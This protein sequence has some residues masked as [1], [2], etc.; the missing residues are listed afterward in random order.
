VVATDLAVEC[1]RAG[2]R[3]LVVEA[4]TILASLAF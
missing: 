3:S 1:G 2:Y 4:F